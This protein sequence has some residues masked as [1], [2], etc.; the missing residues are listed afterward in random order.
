MLPDDIRSEVKTNLKGRTILILIELAY[1]PIK[2]S[3]QTYLS[4][5]LN[6][7]RQ[8]VHDELIRLRDMGYIQLYNSFE[9]LDDIRF[10][11]YSLKKKGIIFLHILKETIA[12]SISHINNEEIIQ[13]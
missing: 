4:E 1:Q 3:H 8:T 12:Y 2:N 11:F 6:I 7:P 10:K 9:L 13:Y 5:K